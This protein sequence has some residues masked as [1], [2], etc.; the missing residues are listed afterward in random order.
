MSL[1]VLHFSTADVLGGSARSA[2]RIHAGLRALGLRSRM[3]VGHR[4]SDDADVRAIAEGP[5]LRRADRLAERATARLGLQYLFLPSNLGLDRHPWVRAADV[6][7]LF[8]IHG[9]YF[10]PRV[11]PRLARRA[12]VVWRLSDM[13]PM[14]GHCAYS[15]DCGKWRTGCGG[16]PDLAAYPALAVDTTAR[17]WRMKR[18]LWRAA[19]PTVVAPSSWTERLARE[20]PLF[21]GAAVHRIPNGIDCDLFRPRDR[22]QARA[23][24]GWPADAT[25]VLFSAHV[26]VDNPRKGTRTLERALARIPPGGDLALAVVGERAEEWRA[27]TPHRVV[28]LGYCDDPETV[29]LANAAA[30]LAVVPSTVENLPNTAIEALACATPVVACDVGGMRDA[31]IDGET[32]LLVPV[33][34]DAALADALVRLIDD[35]DARARMGAAGR[36]LARRVFDQTAEARAFAALYDALVAERRR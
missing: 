11:L 6:I 32:G 35:G 15:G 27:R 23:A 25:V 31:V 21:A 22:A 33:G 28:A 36:D 10:N 16:C 24:L 18:R 29:A 7:Q 26:A 34:D 30:D 2:Y 13:W 9:G 12:P 20:S 1:S 19:R 17:L 4:F 8:N 5:A 3:L 14:T